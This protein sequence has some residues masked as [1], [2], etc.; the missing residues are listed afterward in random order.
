MVMLLIVIDL[1][2]GISHSILGDPHEEDD[3]D[4]DALQASA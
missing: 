3:V 2:G 4:D 1:G